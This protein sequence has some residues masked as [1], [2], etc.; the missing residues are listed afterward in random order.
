M[1][2]LLPP[3]A[4]VAV[5]S[6]KPNATK[7]ILLDQENQGLLIANDNYQQL[8]K[9]EGDLHMISDYCQC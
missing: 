5:P 1:L 4:D 7:Q 6:I 9:N 3:V 2:V 8:L